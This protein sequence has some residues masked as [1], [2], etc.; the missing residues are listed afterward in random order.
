MGIE[1]QATIALSSAEVEYITAAMT[2]SQALWL[3][4]ILEDMGEP[5]DKA[6]KIYCDSKST[7]IL[8]KNLIFHSRAKLLTLNIILS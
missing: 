8:T 2:A 6:V 4:C 7:I 3:K 5:Q 1:K